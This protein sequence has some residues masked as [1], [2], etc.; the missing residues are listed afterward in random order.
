MTILAIIIGAVTGFISAFFGIGGSSIDTPLLRTFLNLPPHLALGTPLPLTILTVAIA[1]LTFWKKHLINFRVAAY[2]LLGG[3]P[4]I[5]LGSYLSSYF[6]GKILM[7]M[8]G[9]LLFFVGIDFVFKSI[10]E[11]N[12]KET[13]QKEKTIPAY[14]IFI[15]AVFIGM[16]SGI[17]A[18]GG[19][20][21][22]IPAFIIFFRMEMH[23]AIATS[24]F[25][26]AGLSIPA[27]FIHYSLGHIDWNYSAAL[28]VGVTPM[29]YVGAKMDL[30]TN[31]KTIKLLFGFL[32]VA[33]AIYFFSDQLSV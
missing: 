30:K 23:R 14:A 33:F 8:T 17:L 1:S 16:L 20:I 18:N 26:V 31:S 24:L 32:L 7:L 2:C 10:R 27:I 22:F 3:I 25:V 11:R 13:I 19:G 6:P 15:L 12:D 5:I 4:S 28:A 9:G 21:L 29:A